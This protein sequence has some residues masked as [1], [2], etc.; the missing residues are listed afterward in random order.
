MIVDG[1]HELISFKQSKWFE[2]CIN[3]NTQRRNFAIRDF[4]KD[5]YKLLNKTFYGKT[6]ENVRN[7]VKIKFINVMIMIEIVEQRSKLTF[8]GIH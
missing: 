3:F 1:V 8:S 2:E 5:F 4:G 6:L 7:R